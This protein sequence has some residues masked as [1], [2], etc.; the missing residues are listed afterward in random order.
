[1]RDSNEHMIELL[2]VKFENNVYSSLVIR[3]INNV[4][5]KVRFSIIPTDYSRLKRIF[6]FRPFENTGVAPYRYF[7]TGSYSKDSK[8]DEL[9]SMDI[10][11]EQLRNHKQFEFQASRKYISNLLW[12]N[13]IAN[14]N[15]IEHLI[16]K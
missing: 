3:S 7:F 11:V 14:R 2:E 12:L 6:Q 4:P 15:Q 13:T 16:E 9:A 1:M 8:D 10:R 5:L